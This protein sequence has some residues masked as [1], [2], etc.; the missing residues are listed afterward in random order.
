M[1]ATPFKPLAHH[2]ARV[3][4]QTGR[5]QNM[6]GIRYYILALLLCAT[7]SHAQDPVPLTDQQKLYGLSL[8]W[9]EAAYNF[10]YFDKQPHVNWDEEYQKFIPQVLAT[11]NTF[12]YYRV[13]ERFSALLKD[14]HT[15]ITYPAGLFRTAMDSPELALAEASHQAI[16]I[17]VAK[18]LEEKIPL[19]SRVIAVDDLPLETHLSNQVFP[20]ISTSSPLYLWSEGVNR[21]LLGEPNTS[22]KI[23]IEKP[24][25]EQATLNLQ[26]NSKKMQNSEF[27]FLP[28]P[29]PKAERFEYRPLA[30]DIAYIALHSFADRKIIEEFNQAYPNIRK[31]KALIIDLR[32]NGGGNTNIGAEILN[33]FSNKD[34]LAS[35]M[36]TRQHVAT[37]KAWG[38]SQLSQG[39]QPG[40]TDYRQFATGN[41]WIDIDSN[42]A[43]LPAPNKNAMIVPTIVL[44]SRNTVSAAEDFL[45][46]ASQLPHFKTLGENTGGTTGQPMRVKLPGGGSFRICTKRDTYPDGREFVGIGIA[47]NIPVDLTPE[48][49]RSGKDVLLDL[50][51]AELLKAQ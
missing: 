10:A 5:L 2:P 35:A 40:N 46:Y 6:K 34:L 4:H 22:V 1:I 42:K 41:A 44:T 32:F 38:N 13:M 33:N 27:S 14:G 8:F 51:I 17:I 24:S 28:R 12:E 36:R 3:T 45:V 50:A 48:I 25:G 23:L 21:A 26:R 9:K 30:N 19:G 7:F 43:T 37:Y 47:P 49:L 15:D 29:W 11:K 39:V 20:F 16:V 18:S 31:A